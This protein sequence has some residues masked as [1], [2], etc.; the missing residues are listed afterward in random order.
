MPNQGHNDHTRREE[1][2]S[3]TK[4]ADMPG[5]IRGSK[6]QRAGDGPKKFVKGRAARRGGKHG[7]K[8]TSFKGVGNPEVK[9]RAHTSH[10]NKSKGKPAGG[11][12][13]FG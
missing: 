6:R 12:L 5:H 2:A 4:T 11:R 9:A 7:K 8:N 1:S 10:R 3:E 13:Q